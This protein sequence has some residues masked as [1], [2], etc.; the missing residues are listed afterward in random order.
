MS[1]Y[2]KSSRITSSGL[3]IIIVFA[4]LLFVATSHAQ[5]TPA[6]I[7]TT[8]QIFDEFGN[9]LEGTNPS[10]DD[11]GIPVVEGDLIQVLDVTAGIHPPDANGNPHP[12]N[13]VVFTTRIGYG[14]SAYVIDPGNFSAAVTPRP[15]GKDIVVRLF[16]APTLSDSSFYGQS[17][18]FSVSSSSDPLHIA[19]IAKTATPIDPNDSDGDGLNNSWEKSYGAD[20]DNPDTDGDGMKDGDEHLAGTNPNDE[21][22]QLVL[23]QMLGAAEVHTEYNEQ[24]KAYDIYQYRDVILGWPS[25]PGKRYVIECTDDPLDTSTY[26]NVTDVITASGSWS[27]TTMVDDFR[28]G[29]R[30]YRVRLVP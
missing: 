28:D 6:K 10:A 27:E 5:W 13:P 19:R 26:S 9:K 23:T 29:H 24:G 4:S 11:Y 12:N 21:K 18:T 17:Q 15:N 2:G 22:S 14:I 30:W 20:A 1:M 25:A 3:H 7:A 8:N 16:N